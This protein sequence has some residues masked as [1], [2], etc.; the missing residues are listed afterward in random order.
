MKY[1]TNNDT[2]IC[3]KQ[4]FKEIDLYIMCIGVMGL[5]YSTNLNTKRVAQFHWFSLKEHG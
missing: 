3:T 1:S 4:Y 5:M 2:S